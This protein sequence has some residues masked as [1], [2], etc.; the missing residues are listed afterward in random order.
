MQDYLQH[1]KILTDKLA[2]SGSP[3]SEE[4]LLLHTLNGL[5]AQYRPFQTSIRTRSATDP[6]SLDELHALLVCEE[7][8]LEDDIIPAATD[9]ATAFS[10]NRATTPSNRGLGFGGRGGRSRGRGRGRYHSGNQTYHPGPHQH[11]GPPQQGGPQ[12]Q[13]PTGPPTPSFPGQYQQHDHRPHCQICQKGGPA[14]AFYIT[15]EPI[16]SIAVDNAI[17]V[18]R[19]ALPRAIKVNNVNPAASLAGTPRTNYVTTRIVTRDVLPKA[20]KMNGPAAADISFM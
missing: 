5:P 7:L 20:I 3:V 9:A 16:N 11:S 4:D 14:F 19:V 18:T 12:Q 8:S 2:M 17:I 6:V 13:S 15:Y 1:I 10:A